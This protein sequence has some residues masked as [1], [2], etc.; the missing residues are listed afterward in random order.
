MRLRRFIIVILVIVVA[1]G[2]G[3]YLNQQAAAKNGSFVLSGTIEVTETNLPTLSGGQVKQVYVTEGDSIKKDQ[4]L[5]DVYSQTAQVNERITSPIDG[6]VLERLV[7]PNEMAAPGSTVLVV[8]PLDQL[9]LKIFVPENRYGQ[10]TLGQTLPVKVDSFPGQTFVG[11]VSFISDKAE[12][13]PRNVQTTDSRQTTVYAVKLNLE[14][15]GG[16]LKPG[17]PADVTFAAN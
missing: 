4:A 3:V 16:K 13:T 6:V 15:T 12:F 7:E 17:M 1:V 10:I 9:Y 11:K 2:V 14:P 5:V 8:A